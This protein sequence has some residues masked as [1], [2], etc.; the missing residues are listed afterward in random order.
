MKEHNPRRV[1]TTYVTDK[2]QRRA[3]LAAQLEASADR[4]CDYLDRLRAG[5]STLKPIEYDRLSDDYRAEKVHYD[6]IDRELQAL[7]EP[8]KTKE[9]LEFKR[10]Y[11]Q[12]KGNKIK[13]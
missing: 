9:Y 1:P 4:I 12:N 13:Y 10:I 8:K 6:R 2:S 7:E 3:Q 5:I 11:Q